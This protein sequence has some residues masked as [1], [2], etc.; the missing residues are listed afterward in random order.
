MNSYKYNAMLHE[1]MFVQVLETS[2]SHKSEESESASAPKDED[3]SVHAC[4]QKG[5]LNFK[6][7][8]TYDRS[9]NAI[10]VMN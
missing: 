10:G 7:L 8:R 3:L 4:M 5:T 9:A 2:I 6:N 1:R